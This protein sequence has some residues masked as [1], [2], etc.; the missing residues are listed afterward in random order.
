LNQRSPSLLALDYGNYE[1]IAVNDR[2]TDRTGEILDG[3]AA[4]SEGKCA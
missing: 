2:S 3:F 4:R 1:I